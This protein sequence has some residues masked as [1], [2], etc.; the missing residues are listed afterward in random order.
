VLSLILWQGL[1]LTLVGIASGLAIGLGGLTTASKLL[2]P[3]LLP[4]TEGLLYETSP[5]DPAALAGAFV[6]TIVVALA[7]TYLPARRATRVDPLVALRDE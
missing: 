7:A 6:L 1:L 3:T 4:P 5:Y 2:P